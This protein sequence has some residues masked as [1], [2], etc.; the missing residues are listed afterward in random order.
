MT[1]DDIDLG[2]LQKMA[3]SGDAD[4]QAL[5]NKI[6]QNLRFEEELVSHVTDMQADVVDGREL[7]DTEQHWLIATEGLMLERGWSSETIN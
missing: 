5:V 1:I 3:S 7:T 6:K 4:A 2:D